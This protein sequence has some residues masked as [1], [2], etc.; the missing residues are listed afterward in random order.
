MESSPTIVSWPVFQDLLWRK[1][2]IEVGR[3]F[4]DKA[5]WL[6]KRYACFSP[7]PSGGAGAGGGAHRGQRN[8]GG[9]GRRGAGGGGQRRAGM[10][11]ESARRAVSEKPKIGGRD[12]STHAIARKEFLSLMNKVTPANVDAFCGR[13]SNILRNDCTEIY[14][15]VAFDMMQRMPAAQDLHMRILLEIDGA[16]FETERAVLRELCR[17]RWDQYVAG[18]GWVPPSDVLAEVPSDD[19]DGFCEFVKWKK[20]ACALVGVWLRMFPTPLLA[21]RA[22]GPAPTPADLWGYLASTIG[23]MIASGNTRALDVILDEAKCF[24]AQARIPE[25]GRQQ[26]RGWHAAAPGLPPAPRFKIYDL[27]EAEFPKKKQ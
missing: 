8:G 20:Y 17:K 26:I 7:A 16:L 14:A 13:V 22:P 15:D 12:L 1:P 23:D 25:E 18:R 6:V 4:L 24:A 11:L 5:E 10:D 2:S 9:N 21:D 19:Y 27:Y 3:A